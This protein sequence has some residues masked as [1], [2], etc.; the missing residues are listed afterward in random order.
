MNWVFVIISAYF[1]LAIVF[2]LDKYILAGPIPSPKVYSFYICVLQAI[3]VVLIPFVDFSVPSNSQF[4]LILVAGAAYVLGLVWFYKGLIQYEASRVTSAV[5][6]MI[7][8]FT[9]LLMFL[10]SKEIPE[11]SSLFALFLLVIGTVLISY[12]KRFTAKSLGISAVSAFF[13]ACQFVLMKYV[14]LENSFWTSFIWL[15]I[16][17]AITALA[18]LFSKEVR[19]GLFRQKSGFKKNTAIL[20]FGTQGLGAA[21][22]ILQNWAV[23]LVPLAA[24]SLVPAFQGVQYVFLL[25]IAILISFKFP[26]LLKEEVSK[27]VIFQKVV[28]I[29]L[30][31]GGIT[32]LSV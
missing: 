11:A 30:I 32:L 21:A 16:G 5:G 8:V 2:L 9:V 14:Y 10:I 19:E 1:L 24:I 4:I 17:V 25:I 12:K 13:W 20:F 22:N 3:T 31:I 27:N 23:A 7:P 15:K 26:Q 6:G 29:L 18:L 28:A